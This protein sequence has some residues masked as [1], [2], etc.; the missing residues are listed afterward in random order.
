MLSKKEYK[1]SKVDKNSLPDDRTF[2]VFG[3][4]LLE[5]MQI[6]KWLA[7]FNEEKMKFVRIEYISFSKY[8]YVYEID[9]VEYYFIASS[10]YRD[11]KIPDEVMVLI[12]N[13]DK[14]DAIIYSLK[15]K[16]VVFGFESTSSTLAGNATWQRTGRTINFLN[17][18]IPFAFLAYGSKIDQSD[19][20]PGKKPRTPSGIFVLLYLMLS[21]KYST[22]ALA[23]FFDHSDPRQSAGIPNI[24]DFRKD[25]FIYVFSVLFNKEKSDDCLKKCIKNMCDYYRGNI[26][27]QDEFSKKVRNYIL[28]EAFVDTL[29]QCINSKK[30]C[31]PLFEKKDIYFEWNPKGIKDRIKD[32]FPQIDIFQLSKNCKAGI[33]FDT[34]SLIK[35][36]DKNNKIYSSKYL[37]KFDEPTIIIPIKLTKTDKGKLIPT[38]DPYNGEISAF[39]ELY[40]QSFPNS[41]IM[42]LLTDHTKLNEYDV[43]LAENRKIYKSISNYASILVDMELKIFNHSTN[44]ADRVN[45]SKFENT[46]ITEDSVTC[47][48]ETILMQENIEPSFINPPCGSWSDMRLYP[49]DLFYYYKRNDERADIAYYNLGTY[50]I[51]ESKDYCNSLK[52][53]IEK[54]YSKVKKIES[55]LQSNINKKIEYKTF[56]IFYGDVSEA[57]DIFVISNFDYCAVLSETD[58]NISMTI[59]EKN[60]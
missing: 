17:Y 32:M 33:C 1:F 53:T 8:V 42:I 52:L 47:F 5:S 27:K 60:I 45:K 56:V 18:G 21:M 29:L 51:G 40:L 11:G 20:N 54:E 43:E 22:P 23:G 9:S 34:R 19:A 7:K 58:K 3:D 49:T 14:P 26:V 48:F 16:K 25:V 55:I 15:E 36:I 57:N 4:N 24:N 2:M 46:K 6:I 13:I 44:K 39:S 30:K 10:Y 12:T 37:S 38:D 31:D 50:Y 41:N 35:E 28:S 59:M